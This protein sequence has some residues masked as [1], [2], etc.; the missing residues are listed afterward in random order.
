MNYVFNDFALFLTNQSVKFKTS[1]PNKKTINGLASL[2]NATNDNITF[3]SNSK[4]ILEL[5]KT[6]AFACIIENDFVKYLPKSCFPI[7]VDDAY[8]VFALSTNFFTTINQPISFIDPTSFI[9]STA[10]I[11]NKIHIKRNVTLS[12]NVNLSEDSIISENVFIGDNVI[13]GK[14]ALIYPNVVI[15][16]S[17]IGDNCTIQS[18]S[19]IGDPG[20][21]FTIKDKISIQHIGN[22]IIGNNVQIGSLTTIDRASLDSTIIGD[23]VRIDNLV[24]IA[25]SVVIGNN[26]I[27]AAQS[28]IAGSTNIGNNCIIA[29]QTA[30]S[31]HLKIGNNVTIAGKSGVTKNINNNEIVAGFPATNIKKW[32][33]SMIRLYKNI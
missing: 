17:I 14:N 6:S 7:I 20:F 28:G 9:H 33:K 32:K 1:C 31:G 25:H 30:I 3:F 29:G 11:P 10:Y 2:I 8:N 5:S 12:K 27:I 22:V 24:Q 13:I 21:G 4:N 18:G 23:N 15:T 16:N 26:T 19:V